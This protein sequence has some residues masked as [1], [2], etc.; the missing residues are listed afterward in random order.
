MKESIRLGHI[1]GIRVGMNWSVL[2]IF[3]LLAFGLAAG[4]LPLAAPGYTQEVYIATG[5]ATAVVFLLSLLAHE[6]SHA[7][8]ARRNGVE[9][10]G[11]TLWLFGG[12]AKL[13]GEARNPGADLRVAGVGPLVSVLLAA[14]FYVATVASA[15][16]GLPDLL[17]S[18]FFWLA[19]INLV[20]AIFNLM[21]AA[22]LDGGRIL[23]AY[24]WRRR[25]D[26]ISAAV[27]ASR[28]GRV[29]G[30]LLIALGLVWFALTGDFGGLWFILIGWFLT[31]A[32]AAE[33]QHAKLSGALGGVTVRDVMTPDPTVAPPGISVDDFIEDYVFG[34]RYS[35]FPLVDDWGRPVGL[36]TLNRLKSVPREDR[37]LVR[38]ADIACPPDEIPLASPEDEVVA[39]LPRMHG[40]SD[41]RVLVVDGGRL[42]GILSPTDIAR[43]LEAA[44]LRD[45]RDSRHL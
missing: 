26:R 44:E 29:F 1:A 4:Q 37:A 22:P 13:G 32:A 2:L 24:L 23:R 17:V 35:T 10:E 27:T 33:E 7:V 39:L 28:A 11:I 15:G 42:V 30:F 21:P 8:V 38:V 25:G 34:H 41:G 31:S 20:L 5:L 43:Q 3:V 6:V 12:V 40:C 9:V 19:M 18:M 14:L 45:P 16:L 36:V